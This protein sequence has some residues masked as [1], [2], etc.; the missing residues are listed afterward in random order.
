MNRTRRVVV[1]GE[2][3]Q[4]PRYEPVLDLPPLSP[5][6]YEALRHHVALHGVLVPILVDG[7]GP[8]R[9]IIDGNHRR[10][11]ADELGYD[12]PEV[13]QAG[14]DEAEMR[15]LARSLNLARRQLSQEQRRQ[16]VADQL[17]ETPGRSNR[18]VAG[19]LG[20]HHA[21]VASVRC[22]LES[23]GQID[24]CP[25]LLGAD[26][27]L[28][29]ARKPPRA[30]LRTPEERRARLEATTLL[31]GDCRDVLPTIPSASVDA[32]VTDP[33]YPEVRREYGRMTEADW[34]DLMK[35]VVAEA[36]RIL[37]PT[38]SMVVVLQPNYESVG[39]MRLWLWEFLLWAAREW[40]LVQDVYAW[41]TDAMPLAGTGRS[42]GLTRQSVKTCVWLGPPGC[43]RDQ[44]RVL[45]TPS[46]R[47]SARRRS[48]LAVREGRS[49]KGY[50]EGTLAGV[51]AE[52]GGTTPFNRLP[53]SNGRQPGGHGDHPSRTA[54]DLAA[55]W[56]R[57]LVPEG[58]VLLDPFAGSGVVLQAGLDEGAGQVIGIDKWA[59]Y[60]DIARGRIV[61]E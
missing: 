47:T 35:G 33:P 13:V 19:R 56:C 14:M 43:Y 60:L 27:R 57:Y 39:R 1:R 34:L 15:T 18:W 44:D 30:V 28:Q 46:S 17:V 26:Q 41:A 48:D 42:Q 49:R 37:K 50:K 5:E 23:T 4:L 10:R 40:N 12:C 20:V 24:Q 59:G 31:H 2:K 3:G 16:L 45:K 32:I 6:Q 11:V 36:R 22:L 51:A 25:A 21:T 61:D 29:P 55:W 53:I 7:D 52:R 9:R 54:Y 38:G 8:V 58:G